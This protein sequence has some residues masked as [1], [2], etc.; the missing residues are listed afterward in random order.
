MART[1]AASRLFS[2]ALLATFATA[3][4]GSDVPLSAAHA[5]SPASP[6]AATVAAAKTPAAP[7]VDADLIPRSVLF[8]N[9]DHAAPDLSLDGKYLATLE[10]VNGVL[11][12][13]LSSTADPSKKRPITT[14]TDRP[15]FRFQ[16]SKQPGKL[17]FFEDQGG[18]ENY[19]L[20]VVDVESG[21][22]V[23]LTPYP[24]VQAELMRTS[25][26]RPGEVLV[27]M[28]D[29]D[30]RYHD[31]YRVEL[32]TGRRTLVLRNDQDFSGFAIDRSL[33]IRL[34]EKTQ[35][36]GSVV[37][38]QRDRRGAFAEPYMTIPFEDTR[39][40]GVEG[41]DRSGRTLYMV[42]S[43]NRDTAALV[44]VDFATKK[45]TVMAEDPR[46][47]VF[48]AAADPRT[49]TPIIVGTEYERVQMRALERGWQA[50]LEY[51][52][53]LA[54]GGNVFFSSMSA[55][56]KKTVVTSTVSDGPATY[57]LYDR[58]SKKAELLFH[59]QDALTKVKLARMQ[60][61]TIPTRDGLSMVSYLTLP[62]GSDANA[63]G[64]PDHP[65]PLVLYVH[66]GPWARDS[67]GYEPTHQWLANRGYA[68][69]SVNYRGSVGFGKKFTDAGNLQWGGKM[70]DDLL[71]AVKWATDSGIADPAK[72]AIHGAS[73][74][75]YATLAAMTLSPDTFACGVDEFG[76]ANLLTF[77]QTIPPYWEA[78]R[79]DLY[80]RVGDPRTE[81]GKAF[82][83]AHSPVTFAGSV[84]RP[85]L[86]GQGANDAR[87]KPS[88]SEQF[89]EA[90]KARNI[91]V[92]YVVFSDEGHGFVRPAN[93]TAFTAASETFFAQCLGGAYEP[94]GGSFAGSTIQVPVGASEVYGLPAAIA[95]HEKDAG[96]GRARWAK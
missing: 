64:K 70:N 1:I 43:R 27:G 76:P 46:A 29:R 55:D 22:T 54:P 19:H 58:S 51:L 3:C 89:V 92:T 21:K 50:D 75:G 72:V 33:S 77:E 23:D 14:S 82:L 26:D 81:E 88:E 6:P 44:A 49:G 63:D 37:Y 65:L 86:I 7:R 93:A 96:G 59:S 9:P 90:M 95:A 68:V 94:I 30:A 28:N 45:S 16:W 36:D 18:D 25:F 39:V 38:Y 41:F 53:T 66:G 31:V 12:L 42:D 62:V 73:Y 2:L 4:G 85:L 69:L 56:G 17:L 8:G 15:I 74:G 79:T 32:A 71:D 57:Y 20:Y 48:E 5:S 60:S 91:P 80:R 24:K 10:P 83:R 40:T 47:D 11:N 67:W 13:V 52:S 61:L 35:A 78:Y 84:K 34:A 87:V